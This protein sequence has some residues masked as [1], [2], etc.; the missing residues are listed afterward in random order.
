MYLINKKYNRVFLGGNFMVV[1]IKSAKYKCEY[2]KFSAFT[3]EGI[4]LNISEYELNKRVP[5]KD[6]EESLK[7][8]NNLNYKKPCTSFSYVVDVECRNVLS[9]DAS[10]TLDVGDYVRINDKE[11]K[12]IKKVGTCHGVDYYIDYKDDA[13]SFEYTKEMFNYEK[14]ILKEK[15]EKYINDI[16]FV[17]TPIENCDIE[18]KF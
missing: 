7:K 1:N 4:L 16:G 15:L 12:I 18:Y 10:Y 5:K 14:S 9:Y 6:L 8:L 2:R 13:T 17:L 11:F 3:G